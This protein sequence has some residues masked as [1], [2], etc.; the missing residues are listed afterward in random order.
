MS[1]IFFSLLTV[2][3]ENFSSTT[4]FSSSESHFDSKLLYNRLIFDALNKPEVSFL[5]GIMTS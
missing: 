5:A 1:I 2:Y 3:A 4:V